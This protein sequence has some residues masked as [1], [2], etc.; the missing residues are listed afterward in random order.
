MIAARFF[1]LSDLKAGGSQ[2]E[3]DIPR[4]VLES[5]TSKFGVTT[6]CTEW[7]VLLFL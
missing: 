6:T 4:H 1:E 3:A 7:D 2:K 5:L